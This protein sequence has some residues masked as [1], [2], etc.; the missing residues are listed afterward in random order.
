VGALMWVLTNVHLRLMNRNGGNQLFTR[1]GHRWHP[2][3]YSVLE[4][5]THPYQL[6]F[7]HGVWLCLLVF[8]VLLAV[9]LDAVA[10]LSWVVV[11]WPLCSGVVLAVAATFTGCGL[12]S[13][14]TDDPVGRGL[15]AG[16]LLALVGLLVTLVQVPLKLDG[17]IAASW[18]VLPRFAATRR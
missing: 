8:A 2:S 4:S 5:M 16:I 12:L 15:R 13:M 11:F 10:A 7:V 9:R 17:L 1:A 14:R 6:F 18:Y 3:I